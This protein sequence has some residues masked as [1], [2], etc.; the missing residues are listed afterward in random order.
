MILAQELDMTALFSTRVRQNSSSK[1]WQNICLLLLPP[2]ADFRNQMVST[3]AN[4][5]VGD[6]RCM[7]SVLGSCLNSYNPILQS[8]NSECFYFWR[9][10]GKK[11]TCIKNKNP[12]SCLTS[13]GRATINLQSF[14]GKMKI[15]NG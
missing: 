2:D 8:E 3:R 14:N 13:M 9:V 5:K 7:V 6:R 10:T 1:L 4:T 12:Y 11:K 15:C